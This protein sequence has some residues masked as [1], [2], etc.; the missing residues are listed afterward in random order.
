MMNTF[1]TLISY[2]MP[3]LVVGLVAY[4][5]FRMHF[6]NEQNRRNFELLKATKKETLPLRIQAYERLVL[7]LERIN[8]SNLL[9]RIKPVGETKEAYYDLLRGTIVQEYEHNL[10]QQIYISE[11][12]WNL[13]TTAKNTTVQIL[14]DVAADVSV[15][16]SQMYREAVL[17]KMLNINPPSAVAISIIKKEVM[18]L[19]S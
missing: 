4:Y 8:P 3:A 5:L 19:M 13:I 1:L 10:S 9:I 17:K 18:E 6:I 11:E 12:S 16:N 7:F 14:S 2:V 15:K